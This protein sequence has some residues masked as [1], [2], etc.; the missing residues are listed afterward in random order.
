MLFI[1]SSAA[2]T[3]ARFQFHTVIN[4]SDNLARQCSV[5]CVTMRCV[6]KYALMLCIIAPAQENEHL[7]NVSHRA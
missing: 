2:L 3:Y 4:S 1:V 6:H 7:L 5:L